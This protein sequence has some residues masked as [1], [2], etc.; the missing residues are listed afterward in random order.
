MAGFALDVEM[1]SSFQYNIVLVVMFIS[2]LLIVFICGRL[3]LGDI[4]TSLRGKK[5]ARST[6]NMSKSH[7]N[8]HEMSVK[9]PEEL[10][11]CLPMKESNL[12]SSDPAAVA[13][14]HEGKQ[15]ADFV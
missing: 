14:M 13:M 9:C 3:L 4:I 6:D 5:T 10:N 11:R 15:H 7:L 2:I 12:S 1:Q 8:A